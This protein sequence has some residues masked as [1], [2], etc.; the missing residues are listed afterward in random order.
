MAS[1]TSVQRQQRTAVSFSTLINRLFTDARF[2]LLW[3]PLRVW[4]G[5]Q[6][7]DAAKHKMDDPAWTQT[8]LAL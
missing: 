4:L 2:A 8:G 7:I 5:F 6:W 1:I 3:L